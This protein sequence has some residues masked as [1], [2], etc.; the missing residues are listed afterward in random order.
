MIETVMSENSGKHH[1]M[2]VKEFAV[3]AFEQSLDSSME[4]DKKFAT[5]KISVRDLD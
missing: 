3:N 1:D 4:N 2:L 5:A